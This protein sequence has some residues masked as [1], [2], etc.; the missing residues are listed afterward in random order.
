MS[1]GA[2]VPSSG[3]VTQWSHGQAPA[4]EHLPCF[5]GLSMDRL[6][7]LGHRLLLPFFLAPGSAGQSPSLG[8]RRASLGTVTP[9]SLILHVHQANSRLLTRRKLALALWAL[10]VRALEQPNSLL[11][12]EDPRLRF[13]MVVAQ[14]A[15]PRVLASL[16]TELSM[17]S[18]M[19]ARD[20]PPT[21]FG[22][23]VFDRVLDRGYI[24][25]HYFIAV[26]FQI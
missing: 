23:R 1:L 18:R 2:Q 3:D 13:Y 11:V 10:A 8:G 14:A 6:L 26:F 17:A 9:N 25:R 21:V 19:L 7:T 22:N 15:S 20:V 24:T 5:L 4:S 12:S 16:N